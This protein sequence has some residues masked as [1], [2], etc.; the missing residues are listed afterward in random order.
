MWRDSFK[1]PPENKTFNGEKYTVFH[2]IEITK[3][4]AEL[5]SDRLRKNGWKIRIVR[6]AYQNGQ[7]GFV[8]YGKR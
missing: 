3:K 6:F 5:E 4:D 2:T 8:L 7:I 1:T